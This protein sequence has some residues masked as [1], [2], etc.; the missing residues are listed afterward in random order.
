MHTDELQ[1][2]V[3]PLNSPESLNESEPGGRASEAG[4]VPELV[5]NMHT[6]SPEQKRKI[7]KK[8]AKRLAQPLNR[9]DLQERGLE[10]I[11]FMLADEKYAIQVRQVREVFPL[12]DLTR[13]PCTPSFVL[14]IINVRGQ[15]ISVVDVREFFDLPKKD[16]TELSKVLIIKNHD[17]EFGIIADEIVGEQ[18]IPLN[19]I[20][21]DMPALR[22]VR[23]EYVRGVT[24]EPVIILDA[25]RLL[26]DDRIIV[27]QEVSE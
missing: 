24:N 7:L 21:S 2:Q 27:H 20:R 4:N 11:V 10:V 14:G 16:V 6:I 25:E 26:S 8:R 3:V 1:R 17:L 13:L 9:E 12:K 5:V 19:Q 15:V 22:G 18:K 23:E